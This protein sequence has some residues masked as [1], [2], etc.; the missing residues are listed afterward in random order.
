MPELHDL[1]DRRASGYGPPVDLFERVHDRRR[2]RERNRRI[3]AGVLGIAVFA[4]AAVGFVRLLGSEGTPASDPRSPFEGTWVS[5]D[6]NGNTQKMT[7][8]VSVDGAFEIVVTD[9]VATACGGTSSTMTG[10]G[11]IEDGSALVIPAPDYRC[12]DGSE[13]EALSG[14][15]LQEQ[16]RDW[17]LV[18]DRETDTLSDGSGGVWVR[19]G[20][21]VPSP[22]PTTSGGMWPQTSLEEVRRAQERADAGDPDYTWQHGPR[23]HPLNA[24]VAGVQLELVDRFIREVLGWEAYR[25]NDFVGGDGDGWGD[26]DL[27]DQRYLRCAP[28]RTNPLYPDESCAP[29]ID[30]LHY[31]TVSLDIAQLDRQGRDGIWVVSGWRLTA[32]F[33]QAD[34]AVVEA[35]AR[36]RLEE[37]L[38]ARVAGTGAD[39]YVQVIDHAGVPRDVPL[40]YASASGA[41]YER[42]EIERVDGPRWPYAWMTFSIRLFADGDATVVEQ[43]ISWHAG[44]GLQLDPNSTTENGH[45]VPLSYTSSDGEVTVSAPSSWFMW[46]HAPEPN[47]EVWHG[48]MGREESQESIGF[49]DP[50]AYDAW[51]ADNGGSPL[52][53]APADA[54]SIAQQV[55]ADPNFETTAPVAARIDGLRAVSMDVA[56]APDGKACGIGIVDVAR[57]IHELGEPGLRL[58]LYLVDLPEGMSVETLAITIVAPEDRFEA[59]IDET[60]PIIESIE[61]HAG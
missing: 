49:V 2:R 27:T 53:S 58:R 38:A 46:W 26:G 47:V 29:T 13:P 33:T 24:P 31:E 54:A 11:Q 48:R 51:C 3:R 60:A 1:L 16:L 45:P 52:L 37:F 19:E 59:V 14:Q 32:P 34:P 23:F 22:E 5:T 28:S 39:G 35:Q 55:I 8:S 9:D 44:V 6:T 21:D 40:L 61:F 7:V 30:D 43:E 42:S 17:T 56:L 20:P 57:W 25:I 10:A 50:V 15:P 36:Q 41:T 4:M 18:L 12:D